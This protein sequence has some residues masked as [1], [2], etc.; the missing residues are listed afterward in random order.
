M[1]EPSSPELKT[2]RAEGLAHFDPGIRFSAVAKDI[3]RPVTMRTSARANYVLVMRNLLKMYTN[4]VPLVSTDSA[5]VARKTVENW[6][7]RF[8]APNMRHTVQKKSF[9]GKLIKEMCRLLG[10]DKTKTY[11][12]R[13]NDNGHIDLHNLK[14]GRFYFKVLC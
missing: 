1:P 11:S 9:V 14:D 12:Y 4:A 7:L 6:V 3:L 13:P 10:N 2:K 5:D 8:V